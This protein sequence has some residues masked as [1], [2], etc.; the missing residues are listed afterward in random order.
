MDWPLYLLVQLSVIHHQSYILSIALSDEHGWAYHGCDL[1]LSRGDCG[2]LQVLNQLPSC[3]L[4]VKLDWSCSSAHNLL[5]LTRLQGDLP[6]RALHR[7]PRQVVADRGRK[8]L[9]HSV[10]HC[11][12]LTISFFLFFSCG[13]VHFGLV[14]RG[15]TFF[16]R[17]GLF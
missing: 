9:E 3:G 10:S 8:L 1:Q 6:C 5:V 17:L 4:Q 16:L 2:L 13:L 14:L 7:A 15:V 11:S 12:A